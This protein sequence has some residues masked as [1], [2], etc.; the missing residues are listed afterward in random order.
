MGKEDSIVLGADTIVA[1]NRMTETE[2]QDYV[3]SKEPMDKAG[4]YGIQGTGAKF[5]KKIHGDY[6]NVVGLPISRIYQEFRQ[7]GIAIFRN[8]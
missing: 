1:F 4:S 7:L 3:K 6:N 5:I 2:I 8:S